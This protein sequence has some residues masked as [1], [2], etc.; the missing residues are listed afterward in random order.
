M[1][2]SKSFPSYAKHKI[3]FEI[4]DSIRKFSAIPRTVLDKKKTIERAM[5]IL[6]SKLCRI[7]TSDEMREY[8]GL[9]ENQYIN[10]MQSFNYGIEFSLNN[11]FQSSNDE[12]E[13]YFE[14]KQKGIL[15]IIEQNEMID[16]INAA[17]NCLSEKERKVMQ[18]R[19]KYNLT[20]KEIAYIM[21]IS[22]STV[23]EIHNRVILYLKSKFNADDN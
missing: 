3:K 22:D 18:L 13:E 20:Y 19:Y 15:D 8:L 7:P 17:I 2:K 5:S 16:N 9:T 1:T 12:V 4:I 23:G 21:N 6:E 10:Y 14:H 11:V